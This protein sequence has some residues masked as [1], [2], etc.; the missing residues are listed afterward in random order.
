MNNSSAN[1]ALI[2]IDYINEIAS[3]EGKLGALKGY[4]AYIQQF[5]AVAALNRLIDRAERDGSLIIFVNL[6]FDEAWLE[7]PKTS[8][9]FGKAHEF[10]ILQH[11]T[12]ST[13]VLPAVHQPE[14]ALHLCKQ[15]VSAFYA[16]PLASILRLHGV[17]R[18]TLAGVATDLAVE[19]AARD[20]HDRDFDVEIA[21]E[22][23]AAA[24]VEDHQRSLETMAKFARVV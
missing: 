21:A 10:G 1:N 6:G 5:G 15:R 13:E 12:W 11:G 18:V 23:C 20:A 17:K 4:A 8:P 19:A 22:A 14:G 7:Q 3:P 9:V 24:S 2:I 16:T